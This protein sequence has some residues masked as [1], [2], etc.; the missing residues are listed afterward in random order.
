MAI[1]FPMPKEFFAGLKIRSS[2]FQLP[3]AMQM[4]GKTA[5]GSILTAGSGARL[6]QGNVELVPMLYAEA[7]A[8]R[9]KLSI[10]REPGRFLFVTPFPVREPAD[11]MPILS[12]VTLSVISSNNREIRLSGLPNGFVLRAGE[13]LSFQYGANP[14]RYAF[15]RI[16]SDQVVSGATQTPAIEVTPPI[17]PGATVGVPVILRRPFFKALIVPGSFKPGTEQGRFVTGISFDIQQTLR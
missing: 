2:S 4:S 12:P 10:L 15:H 13:P 11:S 8:I 3:E 6:W 16:V 9:T 17:R 5:G 7:E 1:H 14:S